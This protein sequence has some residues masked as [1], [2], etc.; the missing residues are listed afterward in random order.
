MQIT[1][2]LLQDLEQDLMTKSVRSNSSLQ[3]IILQTLRQSQ[4][5]S[6]NMAQWS[7]IILNYECILDFPAFESYR[8]ELL[9]LREP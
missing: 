6:H 7:D 1:I 5:A 3:S 2:D 4:R 9:L 8:E